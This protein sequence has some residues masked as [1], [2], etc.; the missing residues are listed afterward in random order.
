MKNQQPDTFVSDLTSRGGQMS[1]AEAERHCARIAQQKEA[2][3]I[4]ERLVKPLKHW[5]D[6][7]L[8][9][10]IHS[11]V[12]CPDVWCEVRLRTTVRAV[13]WPTK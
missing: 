1:P 7:E 11:G 4:Q 10:F 13:R 5:T 8:I 9:A 3:R 12:R 6:E 2:R